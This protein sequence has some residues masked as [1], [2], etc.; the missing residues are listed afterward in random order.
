M[1]PRSQNNSPI[2]YYLTTKLLLPKVHS[3][4]QF[5][6]N[7]RWKF[8][9]WFI[10]TF[11]N[12]ESVVTLSEKQRY[13]LGILRLKF[14]LHCNNPLESVKEVD[15]ERNLCH[16]CIYWMPSFKQEGIFIVKEDDEKEHIKPRRYRARGKR[17]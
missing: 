17:T 12:K 15:R 16:S 9:D 1:K 6:L 11:S 2:Y 3:I 4:R 5:W 10:K 7:L 14:C 13:L 8:F